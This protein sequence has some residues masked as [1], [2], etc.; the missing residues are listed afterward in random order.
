MTIFAHTSHFPGSSS[1]GL[2][3]EGSPGYV[4]Q[5]GDH[6]GNCQDNNQHLVTLRLAAQSARNFVAA[7]LV[8]TAMAGVAFL[9][10]IIWL[11]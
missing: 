4:S 2:P 5:L 11:V 9:G 6:L 10:L 3:A 8:T 7:R 1:N